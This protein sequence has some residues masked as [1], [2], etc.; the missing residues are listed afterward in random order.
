M[1]V[2]ESY[3]VTLKDDGKVMYRWGNL[4]K[5]PNDVRMYAKTPLP[6]EWKET[7]SETSEF[8][9]IT[10]TKAYLVIDHLITNNPND[11]LCP[12]DLENEGATGRKPEYFEDKDI[13]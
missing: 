1:A 2:S 6:A 4:I 3:S 5:R 8:V 12:E 11:Q 13:R 9:N 7:D 10:V